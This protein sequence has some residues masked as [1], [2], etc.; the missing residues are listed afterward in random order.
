MTELKRCKDCVYHKDYESVFD[1]ISSRIFGFPTLHKCF[2]P[3]RWKDVNYVNGT[4]SPNTL[5]AI[6]RCSGSCGR[7]GKNYEARK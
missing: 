2:H 7:I 5:C 1:W 6:E 3:D 4:V